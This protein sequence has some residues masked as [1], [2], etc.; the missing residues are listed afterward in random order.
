M[1]SRASFWAHYNGLAFSKYLCEKNCSQWSRSRYFLFIIPFFPS[2][3][4]FWAARVGAIGWGTALQAGRSR[5]RFP[6]VSIE[7]F[8]DI[9]ISV[10]LFGPGVDSDSNRNEY[11]EYFSGGKGGRCLGLANLQPSCADCL[12]IWEP[13][14]PGTLTACPGL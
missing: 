11:Q 6:M 10:A 2:V 7:F 5:V 1:K 14:L 4:Q 8:I 3:Q 13:Q 12:E 9:F